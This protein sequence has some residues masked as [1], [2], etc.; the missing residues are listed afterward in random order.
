MYR[1]LS[2]R[3]TFGLNIYYIACKNKLKRKPKGKSRDTDN[4]GHTGQRQKTNKQNKMSNR[5]PAKQ[6]TEVNPGAREG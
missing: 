1:D 3:F 5:D 2:L 4:I 6:K